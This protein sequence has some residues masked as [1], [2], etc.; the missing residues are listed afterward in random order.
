WQLAGKPDW[1]YDEGVYTLVGRNLLQQGTLNEHIALGAPWTPFLYQP[2]WYFLVLSRWFAVVGPSVYHARILGVVCSLGTLMLLF[3]LRWRIH[4]ARM[5]LAAV[6]PVIFDG[7]LL[8]IQR[9]SYMENMLLLLVTAA[10]LCYQRA[11]DR[12]SWQR[13]ALAGAVLGF[14]ACFKFTGVYLIPAVLLC[15]LILRRAHKGHFIL[16]GAALLV[17]IADQ[18]IMVSLFDAGRH[19]W[20]IQ[21]NLVQIRRVLGLQQSGGTLTNPLQ[22]VH[23]L[24]AQYAVFVPSFLI[25]LVSF[26]LAVRRLW[27]CYRDRSWARLQPNA[28]LFSWM[29]AGIVVFG[30]SSLRFPQ[31]FALI[32]V[33]MYCYLWTE[34]WQWD[35]VTWKKAA[36]A[37]TAVAAGL[38]S[39]W[40]RVPSRTDNAFAE[41]TAYA[42]RQIPAHSVVVTEEAIG[43]LISQPYCR[44]EEATACAGHAE[45]AI[46]WK[47]YLQS[48]FQLGDAAFLQMMHGAVQVRQFSGFS[49]TA[50]V[51]RLR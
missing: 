10:M 5:A 38:A 50:T 9:I 11:L 18:A 48:S 39:F 49:G 15:W 36:V 14:T 30:L 6:L 4:G 27:T 23:L 3:R 19:D 13:F 17:I 34:V 51:W 8:Y 40:L 22:A 32:L 47:T 31:Y 24:A 37:C 1:Q 41:V 12:P 7:W 45:Y 26:L 46:T 25:A 16:L 29:A 2:M 35:R 20:Y 21:E 33:P 42:T 28:L 43:D 44:V